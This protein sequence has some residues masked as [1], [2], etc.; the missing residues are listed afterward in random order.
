VSSAWEETHVSS[1]HD[2]LLQQQSAC[3]Q[4]LLIMAKAWLYALAGEAA[5]AWVDAGSSVSG[6]ATASAFTRS[7]WAI[8]S[9]ASN[10]AMRPDAKLIN[11]DVT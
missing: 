7:P 8:K 6:A 2:E 9:M 4:T 1:L 3:F 10:E 5:G 11:Q